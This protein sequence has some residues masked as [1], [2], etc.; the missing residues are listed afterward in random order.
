MRGEQD[1]G[2]EE[3]TDDLHA[4]FL[5]QALRHVD[6]DYLASAH[7]GEEVELG[8]RRGEHPRQG[9]DAL[10][11]KEAVDHLLLRAVEL[12]AVELKLEEAPRIGVKLREV[13]FELREALGLH[14][15]DERV[16]RGRGNGEQE[17]NR[18]MEE[19][20]LPARHL[21]RQERAEDI[22]VEG[23]H[24]IAETFALCRRKRRR[25]V[26]AHVETANELI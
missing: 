13:F 20:A 2:D 23:E 16:D 19:R 5:Q 1:H 22:V 14:E 18:E 3:P 12:L 25:L 24:G 9:P 10:N 4:I 15:I 7:F 21:G 8:L 26:Y 17:F 11:R 6:K